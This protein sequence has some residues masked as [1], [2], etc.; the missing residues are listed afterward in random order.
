MLSRARAWRAGHLGLAGVSGAQCMA[1]TPPAP[2]HP[3]GLLA[4]TQQFYMS[5]R[6]SKQLDG[7]RIQLPGSPFTPQQSAALNPR[8]VLY[9]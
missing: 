2:V 9:T 1:C 3:A 7:M 4:S 6:L 5:Y 8:W